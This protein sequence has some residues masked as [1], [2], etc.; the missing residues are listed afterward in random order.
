[1]ARKKKSEKFYMHSTN[2]EIDQSSAE[3]H[4]ILRRIGSTHIVTEYDPS[5]NEAIG[6][7]FIIPIEG[8]R[9]SFSIPIRW[10]NVQGAMRESKVQKQYLYET[11]YKRV[12]WRVA[13]RWVEAQVALIQCGGAET[14]EAF[15]SYAVI[16]EK[17]TT[18][19]QQLKTSGFKQ[20][21]APQ[22]P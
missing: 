2:I 15:M 14:A 19:Y 21:P 22:G 10:E 17:G 16:D 6:V 8:K 3:M 12:A 18:L 4:Q 11:Q 20:L 7:Y 13:L 9:V 1:M 5:T